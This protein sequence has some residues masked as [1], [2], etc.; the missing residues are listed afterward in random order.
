MVT[1]ILEAAGHNVGIATTDDI[2]I[3]GKIV[4]RYDAAGYHGAARVMGDKQVTA[5]VLETARGDLLGRG[6]Y[7][8]RCDVGALLNV[9]NEQL[10]DGGIETVEQMGDLKRMVPDA[11]D[12]AQVLSWDDPYCRSIVDQ[13]DRRKLV[14]FTAHPD[15]QPAR[16]HLAAGGRLVTLV[17]HEGSEWIVL[18]QDGKSENIVATETLPSVLGG[19]ARHNVDNAVAAAAIGVGLD[20]APGDIATGLQR[21]TN[22]VAESPSRFNIL[23][24]FPFQFVVDKAASI[25]A[26]TAVIDSAARMP[27]KGRR[28]CAF[29]ARG[30]RQD[31]TYEKIAACVANRFDEV[32]A[33]EDESFRRG[34]AKGEIVQFLSDGLRAAGQPAATQQTVMSYDATVQ[35]IR[36]TA[37]DGDLVLLA[38]AYVQDV[39]PVLE[40]VF[41]MDPI[42]PS[43][44]D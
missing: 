20:L 11:A 8:S 37:K 21:F 3:D 31:S 39:I 19:I 7:L 28:I 35:L 29:T 22:S 44:V 42:A 26:L 24:G 38:G 14:L 5:A 41:S 30:N 25:P 17:R 36:D 27:V 34:R 6:L 15:E 9:K 40:N 33:Y 13:F 43:T 23:P 12:Q 16:S 10:G 18:R 32:I 2:R 1:R 4:S